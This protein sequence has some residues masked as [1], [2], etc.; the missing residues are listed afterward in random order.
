MRTFAQ[1]PI[2]GRACSLRCTVS[3][4]IPEAE[5]SSVAPFGY[6]DKVL[7][8]RCGTFPSIVE[9]FAVKKLK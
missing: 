1:S 3:H 7:S 4:A 6:L 2:K 5:M 9:G 8:P